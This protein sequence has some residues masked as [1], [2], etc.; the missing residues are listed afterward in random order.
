MQ[1]QPG[2]G[3]PGSEHQLRARQT[4]R[5]VARAVTQASERQAPC[6]A[7]PGGQEANASVLRG[8]AGSSAGAWGRQLIAQKNKLS[9]SHDYIQ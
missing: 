7:E 1:E 2:K 6:L 3:K 4:S 9:S 5:R 8:A